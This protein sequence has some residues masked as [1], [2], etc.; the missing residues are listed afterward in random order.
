V[1]EEQQQQ[2]E[3]SSVQERSYESLVGDKDLTDGIFYVLKDLDIDVDYE[4]KKDIIDTF[5]T[6]KRFF[7]NNL[8]AA[9]VAKSAIDDMDNDSKTILGYALKEIDKLPTFGEGAAP[10]GKK[11]ADYGLAGITDPTNLFSAVAAAF[12][13]GAGG[14]A[15]LAAKEAAKQGVRKYLNAK[16]KAAISK[17]A[18]ASYA[19][20]GTVAGTG[21]VATNVINQKIQQEVGL[22]DKKDGVNLTEAA[23]QGIIEGVA[24]PVIGVL[25]NVA[26]GGVYQLGKASGRKAIQLLPNAQKEGIESGVAWLERNLL[27]AGGASDRQ[28]RLV[29]RQS[30]QAMSFKNRAEDLTTS[31]N[32]VLKRDFTEADIIGEGS[33]INKSLQG[34]KSSLSLVQ[35]KSQ[36]TRNLIDDFFNLRNEAFDF[37]KN[38]SV[39]K[40]ILGI[41]DKDPNY[42]RNVPEKYAVTKRIE[43]YKEFIKRNPY[44]ESELRQAMLL[45]PQNSNWKKFTDEYVEID[46]SGIGKEILD[47]AK[48]DKIV[49][50]AG[51]SLYAPTKELKKETGSFEKRKEDL[52]PTLKKFIGYNNIPGLRIAETINGIVDTASRTNVA[53]DIIGDATRRGLAVTVDK[54]AKNPEAVAKQSLGGEDV[55]PITGS[56]QKISKGEKEDAVMRLPFDAI[57]DS[58]KNVYITKTE[59]KKLK[60]LFDEGFASDIYKRDDI[61]GTVVR[62]FSGV[63]GLSKAGKTIYSPLAHARNIVGAAGYA[64]TSGNL[65]GLLDGAKYISSLSKESKQDIIKE[66]TELGIRGSNIDLNQVLKRFGDMSDKIDDGGIIERLVKSGGLSAFGKPGTKV[67]KAAQEFYGGVDDFFKGAAVFAN[68]KRKSSK[69]FNSFS[70]EQQ[71][72]KLEEFD[73]V[74]NAGRGTSKADDYIK[75]VAAQKTLNLTPVYGRIPKI[76]ENL[77]AFP[78]IGSFTAY[79]AERIRNTYQIFKIGT[80]EL[81]E[82]FE[83]GNKELTKQ[84]IS[85]LAQWSAAQGA[86][87]T[88]AYAMNESN[89]FG[90]VIDGMRNFLPDWEKN[91]AL[92][93]TGK[94]KDGN[95][96]YVDLTYIHP[97]SQFQ[98]AIVPIILKAAR[99][100]DVSKDL[101]ESVINSFKELVDPYVDP[102][103]AFEFSKNMY[104]FVTTGEERNLLKALTAVEP[105]YLNFLKDMARDADAFEKFGETGKDIE[106]A[107]FPEVFGTQDARAEDFSDLAAKSGLPF[108]E[109]LIPIPG[110][111]EKVFNPKKTMAFAISNINRNYKSDRSK[112]FKDLVNDLADPRTEID[113]IS[114]LQDYD[115]I[116]TQ[117]FVAQQ[118]F[119]N[120]YRDMEKVT[121]KKETFEIMKSLK[122]SSKGILPSQKSLASIL[123][124]ERFDPSTMSDKANEFNALDRELIRKTG[125]SYRNNLNNLRRELLALEKFYKSK[126]LNGEPPDL[127]IEAN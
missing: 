60:E 93:V 76:L 91:G 39:S 117:Q 64:I 32:N 115:E 53:R 103:L 3:E 109:G 87:Y 108:I 19:V 85:R 11:I 12:T 70:K 99:G 1:A 21:G 86:L 120:L 67:A 2:Q 37:S 23:V 89:G 26:G 94:D 43:S 18:L 88:G 105:G 106:A 101:D 58:L 81:R 8:I 10:L 34:D 116:L 27:P 104:E 25:G 28:R 17:P 61:I 97:D 114:V 35:N 51:E 124:R 123:N 69:L 30:G 102:S 121:G 52:S 96:K 72:A 66:Y 13:L 77:R 40:K 49:K 45:D 112:F 15:A 90:D 47:D 79:P 100:E 54:A 31:F 46:K 9:P 57:D 48:V 42:V 33:L 68:E 71:A 73:Q 5:L 24:S 111:K 41:F 29:E 82:G 14:A 63:Q 92:V 80:D 127:E 4:N 75:E 16:I 78:V 22:R 62:T 59:G 7:E 50:E 95:Y 126:N 74:F 65:R 36:D 98:N 107:L 20:E 6:R 84:G 56:F 38:S 110:A 44:A 118:A 55:M 83:T 125:L 119:L 113:T 122:D